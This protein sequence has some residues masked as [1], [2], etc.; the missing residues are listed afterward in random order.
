MKKS[1]TLSSK[2]SHDVRTP[3]YVVS[4][5]LYDGSVPFL[6]SDLNCPACNNFLPCKVIKNGMFC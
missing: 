1:G 5:E 4:H 6:V 3:L 2:E